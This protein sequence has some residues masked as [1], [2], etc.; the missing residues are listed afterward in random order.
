MSV[1][2]GRRQLAVPKV[3]LACAAAAVLL[4]VSF[5]SSPASAAPPEAAIRHAG[6][7]GA[8]P[9]SY[10][11]R[12]KDSVVSKA[13]VRAKATALAAARG[14]RLGKVYQHAVRGFEVAVSEKQARQLAADPAVEFVEQNHVVHV[15]G[16]QSPTPSWGLDRI[17]QRALPLTNSYTYPGTG[18][19]VTAYVIDT[20]I[21]FTHREFGG[22]AVSGYDAIDGGTA[23]DGH[24]HGTHVA[25]TIG[26][27]SYG[28]AKGVRLVAV[29][30]LDDDGFGT[31]A[32][33]VAG[34][35]WVT[36]DHDPGERAVA[37]MSLGG[38]PSDL[39]DAA[40]NRSFQDGVTHAVAAGNGDDFGVRQDACDFSPARA[41]NAV[42]VGA[43]QSNDAAASFSNYGT[44][45][46]ILA[47]GV[48]ITSS[49]NASDTATATWD[50]TSMATPHVTGAAALLLEQNPSYTP[51]QVRDYLV[52]NSTT[53]A[54]GNVGT[55]T[56]NRP[57]YVVNLA[58]NDFSIASSPS[59][60]ALDPGG[61]VT[62]AISTQV[63][64]GSA[65]PVALS[66]GGLPAGATATFEPSTVTAGGSAGVTLTTSSTTPA[67]TYTVTLT[68]TGTGAT[69]TATFQLTVNGPPGC[70]AGSATE[71]AIPDLATVESTLSISGCPGN[72]L[73]SSTVEV[74]I[75]HSYIGDLVVS[76]VAP[77]GSAYVLHNRTSGSA[78]S[79]DQT[80]PVNLAGEVAN[81][82]WRLRVQDAAPLDSGYIDSWTLTL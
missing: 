25:G 75:V 79:L 36:A 50:G 15:D 1:S 72:A 48:S 18:A 64:N 59:S 13:S 39:L 58:E 44:C 21:R 35:D 73:A 62:A 43:S 71:L 55:G 51:Q 23:D 69:R 30:V 4:A 67:G 3:V 65:Q 24:G 2:A 52:G 41:P 54:I 28:V 5:G 77:D 34:I 27:S 19:G 74:H 60:A 40:I 33:V 6:G 61:S 31:D 16:T 8:V 10:L 57:L 80:Y 53:N 81:G 47:P 7:S 76:L 22:R 20:G 49:H 82:T 70:S 14:G 56:P 68:G 11:V 45:V 78:G 12:L 66:A 26:G 63:T 17:D 9:G 42:T 32:G 46:D 38:G 37:N 29:R